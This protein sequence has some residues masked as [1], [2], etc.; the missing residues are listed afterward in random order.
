[1][2]A[3]PSAKTDARAD[4][5]LSDRLRANQVNQL[6]QKRSN[7]SSRLP[8]KQHLLDPRRGDPWHLQRAV[9]TAISPKQTSEIKVAE[10]C[11]GEQPTRMIYEEMGNW[12]VKTLVLCNR[13]RIKFRTTIQK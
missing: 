11:L 10:S 5:A 2:F 6:G 7:S 12:Q 13:E 4:R 1:L 3:F 9:A 8:A